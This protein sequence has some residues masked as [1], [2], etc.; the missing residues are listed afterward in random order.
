MVRNQFRTISVPLPGLFSR[1]LKNYSRVGPRRYRS[2][3][4]SMYST[5][6]HGFSLTYAL[7]FD[8]L[9]AFFNSLLENYL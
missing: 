5:V 9:L 2:L 7:H 8:L 3:E 6:C 4:T 1:L